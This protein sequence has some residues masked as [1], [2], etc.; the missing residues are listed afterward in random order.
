[1]GQ[2]YSTENHNEYWEYSMNRVSLKSHLAD[3]NTVKGSQFHLPL[4]EFSGACSGCGETP[5]VK[6][7][8]QMFGERMVIAN[9]SGCS[10]VWGGS[11]GLSPYRTNEKG[12]GPAWARSLFEDAAEYGLG[13]ALGS[14]QRREKLI[15]DMQEIVDMQADGEHMVSKELA[16][17]LEH[18]LKMK[19]DPDKCNDLQFQ[20]K[21]LLEAEAKDGSE[22]VHAVHRGSDLF[23]R[24]SHWIIGGDGWA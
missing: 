12:Q 7:L 2:Q 11:Y 19:D 20:I 9:S 5:Y 8:T 14:Q 1:M 24:P 3:K 10:S 6:L 18:W 21:P 22:L 15:A 13:M 4:L 23:V 17:M 16:S